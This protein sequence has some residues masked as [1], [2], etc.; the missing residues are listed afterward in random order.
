MDNWFVRA[1]AFV[2]GLVIA[3]IGGLGALYMTVWSATQVGAWTILIAIGAAIVATVIIRIGCAL[4]ERSL[5]VPVAEVEAGP[6]DDVTDDDTD[7][8]VVFIDP[9]ASQGATPDS[10]TNRE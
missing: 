1:L 7:D 4:I 3:M 6:D 5:S 8:D 2:V 9:P 10:S